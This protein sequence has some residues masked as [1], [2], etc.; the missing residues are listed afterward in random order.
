LQALEMHLADYTFHLLDTIF[1]CHLWGLKFLQEGS[2]SSARKQQTMIN[3]KIFFTFHVR[4]LAIRY[5]TDL[6]DLH[7]VDDRYKFLWNFNIGLHV[8]PINETVQQLLAIFGAIV[9]RAPGTY[10]F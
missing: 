7:K 6:G 4:E 3:K 10:G 2:I 5:D 9:D 8:N 1:L